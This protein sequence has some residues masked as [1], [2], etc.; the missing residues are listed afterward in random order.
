MVYQ[1]LAYLILILTFEFRLKEAPEML[2]SEV[3]KFEWLKVLKINK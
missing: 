1:I 2:N 3:S